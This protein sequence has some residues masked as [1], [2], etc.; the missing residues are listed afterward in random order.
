MENRCYVVY[1]TNFRALK[2]KGILNRNNLIDYLRNNGLKPK[3]SL[4]NPFS[5]NG[6][7][8]KTTPTFY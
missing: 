3:S 6:K 2:V 5:K 4:L 1:G 7:Q 8:C